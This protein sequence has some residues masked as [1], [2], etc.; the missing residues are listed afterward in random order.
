MSDARETGVPARVLQ[1]FVRVGLIDPLEPRA[2]P[3]FPAAVLPRVWRIQRLRR[4]LH[5]NLEGVGAV[6]ALIERVE[7]LERELRRRR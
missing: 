3:V 4:D 7:E 6:L 1:R 2:E 5:I